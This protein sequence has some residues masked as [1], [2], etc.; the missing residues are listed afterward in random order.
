MKSVI[1]NGKVWGTLTDIND[2]EKI[3]YQFTLYQN[4]PNPFNPSTTIQFTIPN[5]ET[6][7]MAS[8]QQTKLIVY[9]IL[10]REIKVLLN[11]KLSP[12][13]YEVE[14]DGSNLPSGVYFYKLQYGGWSIAK[15]MVLLN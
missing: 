15:K 12:G 13:S 2:E 3:N 14:F 7:Y 6:P 9:D 11:K 4:Y 10:G 5:V 8:L 1:A